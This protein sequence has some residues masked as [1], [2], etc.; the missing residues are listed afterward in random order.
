MFSHH[1]LPVR[2]SLHI[3]IDLVT[4]SENILGPSDA[5]GTL[6]KSTCATLGLNL[7]TDFSGYGPLLPL[8]LMWSPPSLFWVFHW[9]APHRLDL[10]PAPSICGFPTEFRFDFSSV[11]EEI[12]PLTVSVWLL[13]SG[14]NHP[15]CA[16][17]GNNWLAENRP[18]V[19]DLQPRLL[20]PAEPRWSFSEMPAGYCNPLRASKKLCLCTLHY[21][22]STWLLGT[23]AKDAA[24]MTVRM[25]RPNGAAS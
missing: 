14:S 7:H 21:C 9:S 24:K 23:L 18:N 3:V 20:K 22:S 8:V 2:A 12:L 6:L 11:R 16:P 15:V 13:G 1:R 19:Y 25:P 17:S 5:P 4:T 10:G